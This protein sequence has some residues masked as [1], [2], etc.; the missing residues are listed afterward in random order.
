MGATSG[1]DVVRWDFDKIAIALRGGSQH[2]AFV[3]AVNNMWTA[4]I[5][6]QNPDTNA[7]W[8]RIVDDI[9]QTAKPFFSKATNSMPR[10]P[11]YIRLK[12]ERDCLLSKQRA[13]SQAHGLRDQDCSQQLQEIVTAENNN[14]R[15]HCQNVTSRFS[16]EET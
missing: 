3:E 2:H 8:R 15:T 7:H 12:S 6:I 14:C 11:E 5:D 9:K 10:S 13:F 1:H 16:E 4:P